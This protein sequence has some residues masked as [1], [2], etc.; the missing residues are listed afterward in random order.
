[1]LLLED[2]K[3]IST[4]ANN[5]RDFEQLLQLLDSNLRLIT[6]TTQEDDSDSKRYYQLSHDYLVPS[7]Q[8]WLLRK[9]KETRK[10]RAELVLED[11]GRVWN[12]NPENRQLPS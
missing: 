9:Q 5:P 12:M 4:Y 6:P 11:R 8:E 7:L 1:M 3:E 2:L 10:G